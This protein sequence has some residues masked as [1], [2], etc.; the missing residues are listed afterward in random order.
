MAHFIARIADNPFMVGTLIV[1]FVVSLL[2]FRARILRDRISRPRASNSAPVAKAETGRTN[3]AYIA[4]GERAAS[5][6]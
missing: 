4:E 1:C 5:A 2:L 6:H 3:G